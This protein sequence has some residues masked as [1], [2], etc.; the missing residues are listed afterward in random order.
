M[1]INIII[2]ES[3]ILLGIAS[4]IVIYLTY[5]FFK[6]GDLFYHRRM[7]DDKKV[8]SYKSDEK[9]VAVEILLTKEEMEIIQSENIGF[10]SV[11]WYKGIKCNKCDSNYLD[12]NCVQYIDKDVKCTITDFKILGCA[13][14]SLDA[15]N[16]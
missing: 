4:I 13:W 5:S 6:K 15:I 2:M 3:L 7:I 8:D 12:C 1:R 14:C 16:D 9:G 10:V 11:N